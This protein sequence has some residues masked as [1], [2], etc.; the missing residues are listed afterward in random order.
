MKRQTTKDLAQA[1]D[2]YLQWMGSSQYSSHTI[3]LYQWI[4]KHWVAFANASNMA[5]TD[6]FT[7]ETLKA[8]ESESELKS[9]NLAPLRGLARYL[10]ENDQLEEP[11]KKP[12]EALPDIYEEYL[13]HYKDTRNVTQGMI[14][15]CRNIFSGLHQYLYNDD[16]ST[17]TIEQV[18]T[19]L[20][21]YNA[22]YSHK[23]QRIHRSCLR[24]F[25]QYLYYQRS[26]LQRDLSA[27]LTGT[28]FY[29]QAKPPRF[30]RTAEIERL[31]SSLCWER[32]GDIRCN[33]M[34]YLAYTLGLRPKEISLITLDDISFAKKKIVLPNRKN[35]VPLHLPLPEEALKAVAVYMAHARPQIR[36]RALFLTL[37]APYRPIAYFTVSSDI[38]ACLHNAG[39]SESAYCLRHTYAQNLLEAGASIFQVK[40]ML[41]HDRIQTTRRYIHVHT[42]LM[43]KRLFDET[44]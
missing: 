2:A 9:I 7:Y 35:T 8:F 32:P 40:E 6:L 33:A 28:P 31:F 30:L 23:S 44:L 13:G 18:D 3:K 20:R 42:R 25:L 5:L 14:R 21:D 12:R 16:F 43:R 27:F 11:V 15:T 34:I 4:L 41:G 17:L 39:I 37:T 38:S 29:A 22:G 36:H 26:I 10:Y 1:V 19:F 24:G